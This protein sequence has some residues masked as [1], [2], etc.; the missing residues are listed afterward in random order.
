LRWGDISLDRK[1]PFVSVRSSI[2]KNHKQAYLPL[3]PV[4]LNELLRFRPLNTDSGNLVFGRLVPRSDV[5]IEDLKA[6][7]VIKK[8][9][10]GRT[11]DFHSFRHTFCT[12]LHLAGVSMREA[13][14]LMRH[15]DVRLT[16][17]VY[18]DTA[19][20]ALRPAVEKLPWNCSTDD[21]Q[22]DT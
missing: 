2:S 15:S 19:L 5:F 9:S 18:A 7:G 20:F 22:R 6:A 21:A 1:K 10:E 12:N 4:L 8:N 16:M 3:H 14:E 11:L 13:M 17:K